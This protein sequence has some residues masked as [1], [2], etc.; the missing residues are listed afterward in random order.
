MDRIKNLILAVAAV[1]A[2]AGGGVLLDGPSDHELALAQQQDLEDAQRRA[3]AFDRDLRR[4][5]QRVGPTGDLIEIAGTGRYECR[6][7]EIEPTPVHI[8][9]RVTMFWGVQK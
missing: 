6:D 1:A 7:T 2:L 8:L 9:A 3:A 5:K 4:C